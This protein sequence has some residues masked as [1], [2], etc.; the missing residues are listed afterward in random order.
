ML[1][2]SVR[3]DGEHYGELLDLCSG[4]RDLHDGLIRTLHDRSFIDDPTRIFRAVRF[5]QRL[6][7][8]LEADTFRQLREQLDGIS[9]L[10]GQRIW[11]ELRLYCDE[12][13]PEKDFERIVRL[14]IAEKIHK[15]LSW[16]KTIENDCIHFRET[17]PEHFWQ[18][19]SPL[20]FDFVEAEGPLWV[21]LSYFPQKVIAELSERLLMPKKTQRCIEGTAALRERLPSIIHNPSS[22]I[23]FFLETLPLE[24]LYCYALFCT[25]DEEEI[26]KDFITVWRNIHPSLSG[27]DLIELGVK[28]NPQMKGLLSALRAACIDTGLRPEE[29]VEWIRRNQK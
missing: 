12:E 25:E 23:T 26:L 16:D 17:V 3:L 29:E 27:N 7:F 9:N 18:Y 14:G 20:D 24:S 6:N 19:A 1:F 4:L 15:A 22:E 5:E 28:P 8:D 13:A 21:W 11:H 10:T 2:R